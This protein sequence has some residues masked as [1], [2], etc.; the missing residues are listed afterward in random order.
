MSENSSHGSSH[1]SHRSQSHDTQSLT[2]VSGTQITH[3]DDYKPPDSS[4][5]SRA[6]DGISVSSQEDEEF[7]H[8][9]VRDFRVMELQGH[10][11][12]TRGPRYIY[13]D[14]PDMNDSLPHARSKQEEA[15][16]LAAAVAGTIALKLPVYAV[17]AM[18]ATH[19]TSTIPV[20]V[21]LVADSSI[22]LFPQ[23]FTPT[24]DIHVLSGNFKWASGRQAG[25][26]P[27]DI[28]TPQ[29]YPFPTQGCALATGLPGSETFAFT[30]GGILF[31]RAGGG[32]PAENRVPPVYILSAAHPYSP[33]FHPILDDVQPK[34]AIFWPH[35]Q[36][37]ID[38]L[39][40]AES[41]HQGHLRELGKIQTQLRC[42]EAKLQGL[43]A[44]D[45]TEEAMDL[46]QS[47]DA[48]LKEQWR[49]IR[50]I[51]VNVASVQKYVDRT[52]QDSRSGMIKELQHL[53][54]ASDVVAE[55]VVARF[56]IFPFH[57]TPPASRSTP[58]CV[59]QES[60][61]ACS[62]TG[63][64]TSP[65][66]SLAPS[67]LL[68][69]F[70]LARV[71]KPE[72][73]RKLVEHHSQVCEVSPTAGPLILG[74]NVVRLSEL[75]THSFEGQYC[76]HG[77]ISSVPL[78]Y[79]LDDNAVRVS[80][81]SRGAAS[82]LPTKGFCVQGERGQPIFAP[83]GASGALVYEYLGYVPV[84]MI[85][86]IFTSITDQVTLSIILPIQETIEFLEAQVGEEL[87]FQLPD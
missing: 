82:S 33:K 76:Q 77:K 11:E 67:Q 20:I 21:A 41:A 46:A 16:N 71:T 72:I 51:R 68:R 28:D 2:S 52:R 32:Q 9:R 22:D 7:N 63:L 4:P 54:G 56:G 44:T 61:E 48:Q 30:C 5:N 18:Y 53:Q 55:V 24:I 73:V 12:N 64:T 42:A 34:G 80:F 29:P 58:T 49:H 84:G 27:I 8:G 57:L 70:I 40:K 36:W 83:E 45:S 1:E 25:Q 62:A 50:R 86:G 66:A 79:G 15:I 74:Q 37:R 60:T 59:V 19:E 17:K 38:S 87:R 3:P 10:L 13:Q 26:D 14:W 78:F 23:G 65:S 85:T 35:T 39:E 75:A 6:G 81:S 69:D 47:G 43:T 31:G